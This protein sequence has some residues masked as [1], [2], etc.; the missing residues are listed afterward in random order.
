MGQ[1]L[2]A[3]FDIFVWPTLSA[4][5][6]TRTLQRVRNSVVFLNSG[7]SFKQDMSF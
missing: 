2:T 3:E 7:M 5:W 4:A 6:T 1:N